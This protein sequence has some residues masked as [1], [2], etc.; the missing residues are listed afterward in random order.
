[1]VELHVEDAPPLPADLSLY[2][3]A[4]VALEELP[5]EHRTWWDKLWD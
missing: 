5:P 4:P 3:T 1:M 2:D